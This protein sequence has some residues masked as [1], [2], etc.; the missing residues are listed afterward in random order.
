MKLSIL[1]CNLLSRERQLRNLLDHLDVQYAPGPDVEVIVETDK[2]ELSTGAKRN[3]LLD[4]A[5][6]DYIVF[7]DDDDLVAPNY[8]SL[9]LKALESDPDVVGINLIMTTDGEKAERSF[10]SIQFKEW[11]DR[12]YELVNGYKAY[13]RNPNHLNPVKRK[14]ALLTRFPEITEAEDKDYSKRL[15]SYLEN[16]EEVYIEQPIY[17]YLSITK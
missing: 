14:F 8:V 12:P 10:H 16:S 2:G 15:F 1:I 7:I 17:F 13:F 9:I 4:K 5:Q 11:F 6:G 3:K